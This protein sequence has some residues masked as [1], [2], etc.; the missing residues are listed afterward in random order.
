MLVATPGSMAA[1]GRRSLVPF[2]AVGGVAIGM[3]PAAVRRVGQVSSTQSNQGHLSQYGINH[4]LIVTFW[5]HRGRR[6]VRELET[7]GH[8]YRTLRGIGVGSRRAPLRR[9]EPHLR[10]TKT[11]CS[12]TRDHIETIYSMVHGKVALIE[13]AQLPAG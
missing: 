2:H 12:A 11:T 8:E 10:C 3:T 6:R 4:D 1:S 7:G 13:I 5:F 9:A